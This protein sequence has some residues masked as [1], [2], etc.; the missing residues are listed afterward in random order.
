MPFLAPSELPPG[1]ALP[2]MYRNPL[3]MSITK[4]IDAAKAMTTKVRL[5]TY[6][7][8][9]TKPAPGY[10]LYPPFVKTL[11]YP[12]SAGLGKPVVSAGPRH[13]LWFGSGNCDMFAAVEPKR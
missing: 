9:Q 4:Q 6:C 12:V 2:S 7:A 1:T 3:I 11:T 8:K 5:L 13:S 10:E